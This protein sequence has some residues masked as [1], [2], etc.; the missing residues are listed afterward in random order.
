MT[1]ETRLAKSF[2]F[3]AQ[4]PKAFLMKNAGVVSSKKFIE[5]LQTKFDKAKE[6]PISD[7]FEE[8]TAM[9][10]LRNAHAR[11]W[12]ELWCDYPIRTTHQYAEPRIGV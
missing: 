6:K 2:D 4:D 9:L 5:T 10:I 1:N 8:A 11:L 3:I 12:P 7:G